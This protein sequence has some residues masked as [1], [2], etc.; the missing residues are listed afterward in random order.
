MKDE[1]II[2]LLHNA[3]RVAAF[4]KLFKYYGAVRS[5]IVKN[6][7]SAQDAEDVF[8]DAL[9]VLY[10]KTQ[11]PEFKLTSSLETF[12]FGIAKNIWS[13][14]IRKK[15]KDETASIAF[16]SFKLENSDD[17][18]RTSIAER[19]IQFISQQCKEILELFYLKRKS[20]EEIATL[21]SYSSVNAAKTAKYKCLEKAKSEFQNLLNLESK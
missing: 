21:Q 15:Q 1:Q 19:A 16:E 18:Y 2:Q 8:Q 5:H 4:K 9:I 6:S 12:L 20:M 13:E 3:D 10:N 7:G 11:S 14:K 17:E